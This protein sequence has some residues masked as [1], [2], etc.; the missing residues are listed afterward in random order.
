MW[1]WLLGLPCW[2]LGVWVA[3]S[4]EVAKWPLSPWLWRA[5]V[6]GVSVVCS[7]L[8]FHGNVSYVWSLNPFAFLC[9]G[10]VLAEVRY[11]QAHEPLSWL[12]AAGKGSYSLYLTH[13]HGHALA[14]RIGLTGPASYLAIG[15]VAVA[16]YFCVEKPAHRLARRVTLTRTVAPLAAA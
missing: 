2:L 3:E 7:V 14:E 9:A 15:L 4:V 6:L 16:I 10:W 12:E 13:M 8:R 5:A 1:N 11:W